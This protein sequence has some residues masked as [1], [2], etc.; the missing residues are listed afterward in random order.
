MS[1]WSQILFFSSVG[2]REKLE[3]EA[4]WL[5]VQLSQMD[6]TLSVGGSMTRENQVARFLLENEGTG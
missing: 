5:E 6:W 2:L 1:L 3:G 4:R